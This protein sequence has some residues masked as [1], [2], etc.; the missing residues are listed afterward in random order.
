M[1]NNKGTEICGLCEC[2]TNYFGKTCECST[3]A[4]RLID[5]STACKYEN[6]TEIC[7]G[8]GNCICGQCTCTNSARYTGSFCECDNNNCL[9]SNEL[10]CAG[11]GKCDCGVCKCDSGGQE[12]VST[13]FEPESEEECSGHGN[14]IC[15]KCRCEG[16]YSGEYCEKCVHES[17]PNKCEEL[18]HC[19]QC[20]LYGTGVFNPADCD[21]NCFQHSINK[22]EVV[23][24]VSGTGT[25]EIICKAEDPSDECVFIFS[26]VTSKSKKIK[27]NAQVTKECPPQAPIF[28]IVASVSS[29]VVLIGLILLC[30]Y[31]AYTKIQIKKEFAAYDNERKEVAWG[32]ETNPIY[33]NPVGTF[34]N[35]LYAGAEK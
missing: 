26:Y 33:N 1:C 12:T 19:V 24:P 17:C 4:G 27:I 21:L 32:Q 2:N 31:K 22:V 9:L 10:L 5:L 23:S 8:R 14:C 25:D 30:V 35:P 20:K 6:S 3:D 13:C 28:W 34:Q 29:L 11:H 18:K 16:K 7:S 15:G